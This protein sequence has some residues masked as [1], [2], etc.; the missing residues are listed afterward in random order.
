[1]HQ[2]ER[3]LVKN[4]LTVKLYE[5]SRK[6]R[7][8]F[9]FS[10]VLVCGKHKTTGIREEFTFLIKWFIPLD[11]V[12]KMED[13]EGEPKETKPANLVSLKTTTSSL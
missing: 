13:P 11:E 2:S 1:M 4:S 5:G 8:V 10:D 7:H 3:E 9:L 6:L 12:R